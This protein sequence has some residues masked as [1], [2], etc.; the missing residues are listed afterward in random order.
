M[1]DPPQLSSL[2]RILASRKVSHR[3]EHALIHAPKLAS[4]G[5]DGP[6]IDRAEARYRRDDRERLRAQ[7]AVG[8]LRAA[9]DVMLRQAERDAAEARA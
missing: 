6:D 4:V 2:L 3:S 8:D 9:K 7:V 5:V 1:V